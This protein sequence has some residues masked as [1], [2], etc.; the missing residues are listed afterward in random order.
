MGILV[1]VAY[2]PRPGKEALL[3]KLTQEHVP[4]LRGEGLA[5]ERPAYAMRAKD[6]TL[7]EVFEWKSQAAIEAAHTNPALAKLWQRYAE[8]C[9]YVPLKD[10][11]ESSDLFAGFEPIELS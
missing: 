9:E 1:I 6:G 8:A 4:I 2:R 3:M 11:K 10:V 5:T 7:I